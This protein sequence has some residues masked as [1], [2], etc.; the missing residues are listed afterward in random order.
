[1]RA[2]WRF[3]R[4]SQKMREVAP[5]LRFEK[6]QSMGGVMRRAERRAKVARRMAVV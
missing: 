2:D 6:C 3:R 5:M 4:R 1:L